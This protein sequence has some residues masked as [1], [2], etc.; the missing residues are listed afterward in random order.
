M[1]SLVVIAYYVSIILVSL[2]DCFVCYVVTK[3]KDDILTGALK[4]LVWPYFFRVPS[5][6]ELLLGWTT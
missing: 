5:L 6:W 4:L 1:M 3:P 2:I